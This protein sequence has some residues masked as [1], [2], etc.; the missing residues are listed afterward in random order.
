MS[1]IPGTALAPLVRGLYLE[2]LSRPIVVVG[3]PSPSRPGAE[4]LEVELPPPLASDEAAAAAAMTA[5]LSAWRSARSARPDLLPAC[6]KLSSE[7]SA[8]WLYPARG[9][10]EARARAAA[11][12]AAPWTRAELGPPTPAGGAAAGRDR[13]VEGRIAL[14]TGGAQGFGEE[15]VR[16]LAASGALVFV[17]DLNVEGAGRLAAS[18]CAAEGRT[19]AIPVAVNVTDESSV[20]AMFAE[21][22]RAAGGMD[23]VVSNAGVLKAASILEQDASAFRFVTDV[24]YTGFF[25]VAK[26]AARVLRAQWR[27]APRWRSDIVQINSKS[28]LEGSNRNGAYAGSK[29]GGIGLVQSYALELVDYGV[30]VNAICPGNFFDGPLWSDPENGLFVQYLRSGKVPGARTV[31]DVKAFYEAKVPMG[32]GCEGADV[33]RAI[34]YIVEQEYETGQALPVTGGQVML[35]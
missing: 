9:I 13:V 20:A 11:G 18:L 12:D 1:D 21:A 35:S 29:F 6:V 5:A 3:G 10:D 19:C 25:H 27:C 31:A 8:T 22:I 4:V 14:V 30:K 16:A 26:H 32:R 2:I 33:M 34:Y 7:G 28:G 23:L 15:I 24:N 17:A